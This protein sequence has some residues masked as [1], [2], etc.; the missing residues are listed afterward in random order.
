[1]GVDGKGADRRSGGLPEWGALLELHGGE[2]ADWRP[3]SGFRGEHVGEVCSWA[4]WGANF[5]RC[6]SRVAAFDAI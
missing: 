1:M 5:P 3:R 4:W 6:R 2:S